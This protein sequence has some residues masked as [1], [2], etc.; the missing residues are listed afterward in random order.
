MR[1]FQLEA[2]G[3]IPMV[4]VDNADL[5]LA[6][7]ASVNGAYFSTGQRCT[8]SPHRDRRN[9]RPRRRS[10][11]RTAGA[12]LLCSVG[13][14]DR[15]AGRA[16][17]QPDHLRADSARARGTFIADVYGQLTDVPLIVP[18]VNPDAVESC[19]RRGWSWR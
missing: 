9:S 2:G 18:E 14:E 6:V 7:E 12:H 16:D 13:R 15:R 5:N 8:T 10:D 17:R 4:V 11:D 1:K 19:A 3:K